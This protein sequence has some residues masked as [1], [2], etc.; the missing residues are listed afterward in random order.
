MSKSYFLL[1]PDIAIS[2]ILKNSCL[3]ILESLIIKTMLSI[4]NN[5]FIPLMDVICYSSNKFLTLSICS[6][7]AYIK[8]ILFLCILY[9]VF[10]NLKIMR[11]SI[12]IKY[13]KENNLLL[14]FVY[15]ISDL[16]VLI[17]LI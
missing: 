10:I 3:I 2:I 1:S 16:I 8:I 5:V 4:S 12:N 6:L 13:K 11:E 14:S 15:I 7:F 17:D 9:S